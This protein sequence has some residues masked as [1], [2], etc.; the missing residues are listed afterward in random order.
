MRDANLADLNEKIVLLPAKAAGK[1]VY[2]A[3]ILHANNLKVA[4]LLDSDNA[5]DQAAKQETLVHTLG[6][7]NILRTGDVCPGSITKPEIE[8]RQP[9]KQGAGCVPDDI[10]PLVSGG[11]LARRN[12]RPGSDSRLRPDLCQCRPDTQVP[13]RHQQLCR[14]QSA[15]SCYLR[16]IADFLGGYYLQPTLGSGTETRP[17]PSDW[18]RPH[19]A[20]RPTPFPAGSASPT[21]SSAPSAPPPQPPDVGG[22]VPSC[23]ASAGGATALDTLSN[24]AAAVS[25]LLLQSSPCLWRC[26][27]GGFQGVRT[28]LWTNDNTIYR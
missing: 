7:K 5:G 15:V 9:V 19:G 24:R 6:N 1:V 4:A 28:P 13:I 21:S 8:E 17:P 2:F 16:T 14:A 3:T 25:T 11:E 27:A 26:P 12:R 22:D 23:P 20:P 18:T 10:E